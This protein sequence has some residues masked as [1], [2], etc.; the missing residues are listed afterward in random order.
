MEKI[1][2][3]DLFFLYGRLSVRD[4]SNLI[5][6]EDMVTSEHLV[7]VLFIVPKYSQKDCRLDS[8]LD[9]IEEEFNQ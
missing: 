7:T 5:K 8:L 3:I 9:V 6:P 4:L 2:R 1:V